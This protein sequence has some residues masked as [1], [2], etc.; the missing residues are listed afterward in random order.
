MVTWQQQ[1]LGV[2]VSHLQVSVT[3]IDIESIISIASL[4][5]AVLL[6]LDV[7]QATAVCPSLALHVQPFVPAAP[8]LLSSTF[9]SLLMASIT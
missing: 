7:S 9:D 4:F 8:S 1:A 6:H 2:V 5:N 3:S